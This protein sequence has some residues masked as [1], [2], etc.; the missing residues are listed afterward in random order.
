MADQVQSVLRAFDVL[1]ALAAHDDAVALA[2]L[3]ERTGLARSTT[4]RLLT[5]LESIAMVTRGPTRGTWMPGPGLAAITGSAQTISHLL[6]VAHPY[7]REAVDHFGEDAALAV[8]DGF[9]LIYVDQAHSPHP[10]QVPD[11]TGQRFAPHTVAGGFVLMAW[12]PAPKLDAYLSGGL[13][14]ATERTLVDPD[15]IHARLGVIRHRGH[16][17]AS[18]EWI[19]GISAVAA[20][21]MAAQDRPLAALTVFGPAFRF[22]DERSRDQI[23]RELR[24]V[25][26][27]LADAMIGP[28]S[29]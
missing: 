11:W 8:T 7:L 14:R 15:A 27:R 26:D 20:P 25:A 21:V 22:P 16:G 1:R 18:G 19:D 17:W 6:G 3:A 28:P 13:P 5:T 12:W 4:S 10:V 9:D 23:G 29:R 2:A 24:A